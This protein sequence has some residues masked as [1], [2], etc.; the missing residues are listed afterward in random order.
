[1]NVKKV[2]GQYHFPVYNQPFDAMFDD[3]P[4]LLLD[5]VPVFDFNKWINYDPLKIRRLDVLTRQ[6]YLGN[7]SFDGVVNFTTYAGDLSGYELDPHAVA[8]D[9]EGLQMQREFFS[10]VRLPQSFILVTR[11]QN[12]SAGQKAGEF[13]YFRFTGKICRGITRYHG[14]WKN[15]Q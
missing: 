10:P 6:Y 9:Y 2:R 14:E 3:D 15:R 11:Y 5:G 7:L 4:L 8:L 1:V 13:L 12:R